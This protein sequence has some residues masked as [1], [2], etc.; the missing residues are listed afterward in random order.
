MNWFIP[1]LVNRGARGWWGTSPAEGTSVWLCWT[2]KSRKARRSPFASMEPTYRPCRGAPDR[3][4][5]LGASQDFAVLAHDEG[6][7]QAP[8]GLRSA[9]RPGPFTAREPEAA[10][11]NRAPLVDHYLAAQGALPMR[12]VDVHEQPR[13]VARVDHDLAHA[14][15]ACLQRHVVGAGDGPCTAK[16]RVGVASRQGHAQA[17][18]RPYQQHGGHGGGGGQARP[19]REG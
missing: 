3:L 10:Q 5:K 12:C 9:G 8:R 16:M 7:A 15:R 6:L 14:V 11:R 4:G 19:A 18:P 13:R 1:A 2:K 17:R